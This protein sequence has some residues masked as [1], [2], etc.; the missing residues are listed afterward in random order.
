MDTF[1]DNDDAA[2]KVV[3]LPGGDLSI[4]GLPTDCHLVHVNRSARSS[5][6]TGFSE[7]ILSTFLVKVLYH[8]NSSTTP[9]RTTLSRLHQSSR[10][11]RTAEAELHVAVHV[12]MQLHAVPTRLLVGASGDLNGML[13]LVMRKG[14]SLHDMLEHRQLAWG[15][16]SQAT[17]RDMLAS[18][19]WDVCAY[20]R[21]LHCGLGFEKSVQLAHCDVSVFNVVV[22]CDGRAH[23][24]DFGEV[25]PVAG[26]NWRFEGYSSG[27]FTPGCCDPRVEASDTL[28]VPDTTVDLYALAATIDA[29]CAYT[30]CDTPSCINKLLSDM[31]DTDVSRRPSAEAVMERCTDMCIGHDGLE[32][33]RTRW[34]EFMASAN[35]DGLAQRGSLA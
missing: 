1:D 5:Y 31:R 25:R 30:S 3:W 8:P 23:L 35:P 15:S 32:V 2:V 10:R 18:L 22:T 19:I 11:N 13:F 16:R 6:F 7:P 28:D 4:D 12:T 20:L 34:S 24:I 14:V 33:G 29:F 26:Q 9:Q 21:C 27:G 17:V